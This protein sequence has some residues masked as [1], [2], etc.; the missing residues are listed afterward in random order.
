MG[1]GDGLG[2]FL[3]TRRPFGRL[4]NDA[5]GILVLV[6]TDRCRDSVDIEV[7]GL[8]D[9]L[10]DSVQLVNDG[11]SAFHRELPA[12]SSSGVQI[13]GGVRPAD[14]QIAS[15]VPAWRRSR[16]ACSST[17]TNSR[18]GE[19]R[20]YRCEMH[21]LSPS[22]EGRLGESAHQRA[23]S[24]PRRPGRETTAPT[25]SDSASAATPTEGTH[26]GDP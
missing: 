21:R 1:S 18:S 22:S 14:R 16:C 2:G 6:L 4:A 26:K 9:V 13:I 11:V 5:L 24:P 19:R 17:S 15:I 20:R 10:S 3:R 23:E 7:V 8:A 25:T 12:G